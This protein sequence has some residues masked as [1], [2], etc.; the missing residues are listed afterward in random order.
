MRSRGL[1]LAVAGIAGMALASPTLSASLTVSVTVI[2]PCTIDLADSAPV[3]RGC[4]DRAPARP[5]QVRRAV[6]PLATSGLDPGAQKEA[7]ATRVD[8]VF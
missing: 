2:A 3:V 7:T 8:V 5:H 4:G 6:E 1:R